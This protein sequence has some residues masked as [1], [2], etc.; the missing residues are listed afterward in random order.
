MHLLFILYL[1]YFGMP[2]ILVR[3]MSIKTPSEM[4]TSRRIATV[5]VVLALI[6]AI[7]V[8]NGQ[9]P[10]LRTSDVLKCT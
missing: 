9:I 2:H 8:G 5:W 6:G 10:K 4:K 1:V 7:A 3:F